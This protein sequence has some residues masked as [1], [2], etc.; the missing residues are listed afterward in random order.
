VGLGAGLVVVLGLLLCGCG[1][2]PTGLAIEAVAVPAPVPGPAAPALRVAGRHFLDPQGRV[3]ILR[4]VN[5]AGDSKV[6]PFRPISDVRDLDPL[7][8]LGCNVVRLLFTWEAFE[9][10]RGEYDHAYLDDLRRTA[11]ACAGRGLFVI[12]DIHQDG[13]SRFASRGAGDGFPAWAVSPRGT[14]STPANGPESARWPLLMASDPTTHRSFEDF[15]AD[16]QGVRTAYLEMLDRVASAFATLPGVIGYDPLNEPWGDERRD[17]APLYADAARVLHAQ[18]PGAILFLEGHVTT[19]A[20]LPT[21]LPEPGFRPV[22]YA[23]HYYRPLTLVFQ[24]WHGMGVDIE[25]AFRAMEGP[26]RSWGVPLFVGEFGVDADAVGGAA[27]IDALYDRLDARLASGAQWNYTPHWNATAKDGWNGED[28][29]ILDDRRAVRANFPPRPYPRATAGEPVAFAFV[30]DPA[31]GGT[32]TFSWRND[33]ARGETEVFLPRAV[34]DPRRTRVEVS[35]KDAA[36]T[37]DEESQVLWLRSLRP[38]TVEVRV[39]GEPPAPTRQEPQRDAAT[40]AG[41]TP[42]L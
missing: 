2:R 27:Y 33:P 42:F 16:A 28:F 26:A 37:R 10:R 20:G 15:F 35:P 29:S 9:P 1:V 17:L 19:N 5:L 34:F 23:P 31:G 4:G 12:V 30:R 25:A 40:S 8:T 32:L 38:G 21:A 3:V 6:P 39:V 18:H 24:R 11:A 22:A 14:P 36:W 41:V 13:F 7:V